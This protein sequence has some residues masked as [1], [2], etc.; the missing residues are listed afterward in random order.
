MAE[1]HEED[2]N[3]PEGGNPE[4]GS[5]GSEAEPKTVEVNGQKFIADDSG[6]PKI[7]EDGKMI[8]F[9]EK[10]KTFEETPEARKARLERQTEQHRQKFPHL[11][12][13][14]DGKKK[15]TK[16]GDKSDELDYG[17]KA[18]LVAKG[19]ED[20]DEVAL[21]QEVMGES[22]KNLEGVLGSGYFQSRL[23]ELRDGK[24]TE[25]AVPKS[26]NRS[27]NTASNTVEYWIAKGTLPPNTPE[28]RELRQRVVNEK[29]KRE[30]AA[31]NFTDN[32]VVGG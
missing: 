13:S 19:I 31:N 4:G 18:Y 22:G 17:Q 14:E 32:P 24:T 16:K 25:G 29:L 7:G 5:E 23:K 6:S 28:N 12:D 8:P 10:K 2:D 11:Y 20:A 9:V 21:V 15:S 27:G 3:N 1:N 26:G 30:K